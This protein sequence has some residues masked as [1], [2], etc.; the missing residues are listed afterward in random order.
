MFI[1]VVY[2]LGY[3]IMIINRAFYKA[4]G[5]GRTVCLA[6]GFIGTPIHELGHAFMCLVFFH[7]IVDIKLYQIDDESGTLGY[8]SHTYNKR[9]IY[10]VIGNYFIGVA[11]IFC[12]GIVLYL[13]MKFLLPSSF[14]AVASSIEGVVASQQYGLNMGIFSE[15]ITVFFDML[16]GIFLI[17]FSWKTIW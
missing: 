8:V 17:E 11:P 15:L 4:V 16:S 13:L 12:G 3:I 1:G 2:L 6:T 14:T 5:A 7:K 10:H 9:N